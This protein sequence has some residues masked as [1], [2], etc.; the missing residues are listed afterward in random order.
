MRTFEVTIKLNADTQRD[1]DELMK[2]VRRL[3]DKEGV[4][5]KLPPDPRQDALPLAEPTH[6]N[7]D[8][9]KMLRQRVIELEKEATLLREVNV[10]QANE[11]NEKAKESE[12]RRLLLVELRQQHEQRCFEI[13]ALKGDIQ[14]AEDKAKSFLGACQVH[15]QK[16]HEKGV[17]VD[18][19]TKEVTALRLD[20]ANRDEQIKIYHDTWYSGGPEKGKPVAHS[21]RV[22]SAFHDDGQ[23]RTGF[24]QPQAPAQPKVVRWQQSP[25]STLS[26]VEVD[27]SPALKPEAMKGAEDQQGGED[28]PSQP[29]SDCNACFSDSTGHC[30]K[31]PAK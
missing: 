14:A 12:H 15:S 19:L 23:K 22:S 17:L 29:A 27:L 9:V 4:E 8:E 24:T 6:P 16:A 31:H 25:D 1:Q 28:F 2:V 26:A 30:Y 7:F 10:R 18:A 20:V 13:S 11:I 21:N 5:V 3:T